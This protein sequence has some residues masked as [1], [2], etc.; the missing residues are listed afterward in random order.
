MVGYADG[1]LKF[2]VGGWKEH[3]VYKAMLV[4]VVS[5]GSV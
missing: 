4:A 1:E 2:R 5:M 3:V